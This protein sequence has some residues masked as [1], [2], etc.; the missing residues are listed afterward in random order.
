MNEC[1]MIADSTAKRV[2]EALDLPPSTS[3]ECQYVCMYSS[4]SHVLDK[5]FTSNAVGSMPPS[6]GIRMTSS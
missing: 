5:C 2:C 3:G 4:I 6:L 1:G